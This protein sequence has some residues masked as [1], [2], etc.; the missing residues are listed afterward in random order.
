MTDAFNEQCEINAKNIRALDTLQTQYDQA[1]QAVTELTRSPEGMELSGVVSCAWQHQVL[2]RLEKVVE[3]LAGQL[4]AAELALKR[5]TA[6]TMMRLA[7][8]EAQAI[9][10]ETDT[11]RMT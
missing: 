7:A 10:D 5:S 2:V 9:R 6:R 1:A 11:G 3:R 8:S 4:E